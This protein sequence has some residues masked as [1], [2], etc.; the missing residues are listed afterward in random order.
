MR[1]KGKKVTKKQYNSILAGV[2]FFFVFILAVVTVLNIKNSANLRGIL[3]ESVKSQLIS[4]SLAAREMIDVDAFMQYGDASAEQLEPYRKTLEKLRSLAENVGAKYIY[5]LK[6]RGL[7]YIFIFDIDLEK[8]AAFTP[9][10]LSP[11][12]E[13]AFAGR[14]SADI[15]NMEDEY[16]SFNTGAVPI[17]RNGEIVGIICTDIEDSYLGSSFKTALLNAVLLTV[18]LVLTMAMMFYAIVKLLRNIRDMQEKL[19][20]QALYDQITGL[21]NRQYLMEHL[22]EIT[23][24]PDKPSFALLF[25]DLDNFKKVNDNAGHDAGDELLK[26]I[27]GFLDKVSNGAKSFRPS[28]GMLNI[29]ARVGGDEFVQVVNGVDSTAKA[30]EAALHILNEFKKAGL[31]RHIEKYNVGLSIGAALYPR[32]SENY[33]VLIKY[34]DIAMYHAK[35]GGK[36]QC[37]VYSDEMGQEK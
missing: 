33:H 3:T 28:A 1:K 2:L 37:R 9:Y 16:G 21:P 27:A 19:R 26:S 35:H 4:T 34:A 23:S 11:V 18:I 7:E 13:A 24:W 14:N 8:P 36:N 25:I 5:A 31:S 32:D 12:H 10:K 6:R 20:R 29:A 22:A 30:E 17:L 15:M